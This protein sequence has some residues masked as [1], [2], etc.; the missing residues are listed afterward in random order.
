MAG[1][2]DFSQA[3]AEKIREAAPVA[4]AGARGADAPAGPL[5]HV[6]AWSDGSSRGNPGPGGYGAVVRYTDPN[7]GVHERE[8]SQGYAKTTNNRMELLG[9]IVALE[10]LRRPCQVDFYTDSQYVCNAFK[11][12]WIEGW[13]RRGWQT[14]GK[15]PVKNVDLWKRLIAAADAHQ[16]S[17]HWVKGHAGHP[18]NERCDHLATAAADGG[19][20]LADT[21]FVG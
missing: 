19:G 20:L 11:Q 21:G 4:R 7:G 1:W 10:A 14:A 8:F 18:E 2:N 5:M 17:W 9:A 15:K 3:N 12:H 13:L 6:E 16:V